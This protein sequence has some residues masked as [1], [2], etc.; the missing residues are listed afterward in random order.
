MR[1]FHDHLDLTLPATKTDPFRQGITLT[2]AATDD[3]ACAVKA[4][5]HP[6][7]W[8]TAPEDPLFQLNGVAFITGEVTNSTTY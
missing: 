7:S 5:R 6:F 3:D 1:L 4:L 2:A 8:E